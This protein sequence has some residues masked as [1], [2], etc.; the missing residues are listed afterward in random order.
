MSFSRYLG[1]S[2]SLAAMLFLAGSAQADQA[3]MG[4]QAV[5][6]LFTSQGCSSCPPADALLGQIAD[7]PSIV[8]LA[9]HVNYWDYIGWADTFG[10]EANSAHQ[11][12]YAK[13]WNSARIYTPQMVINGTKGVVGSRQNDIAAA[14]ASAALPV[15]VTLSSDGTTLTVAISGDLDLPDAVVWLVS[16]IDAVD[17]VIGRGENAG[18]VGHYINVVTGRQVVGVWEAASGAQLKLPL[19][20]VLS[21]NS[22]SLAILV[23]QERDGLPG[24]ILGAATLTP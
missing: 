3:R 6:E 2:I 1:A 21:G 4:T 16:Y 12:D 19:R 17:V 7:D 24:P 9:Y 5:V 13:S 14:L 10:A 18:T 8:A 22:T 23:Q 11:R 20:E 15:P